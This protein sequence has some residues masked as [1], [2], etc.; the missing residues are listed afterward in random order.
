M[1][2]ITKRRPSEDTKL[3]YPEEILQRKCSN[4]STP[5]TKI[6]GASCLL[7]SVDETYWLWQDRKAI[8]DIQELRLAH[9]LLLLQVLVK[10][11]G[12]PQLRYPSSWNP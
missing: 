2:R 11:E 7:I 6:A 9:F 8:A 4:G 1:K 12:K 10:G 5:E 3:K